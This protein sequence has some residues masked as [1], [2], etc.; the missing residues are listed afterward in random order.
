[1][2]GTWN[3]D[4]HP[5]GHVGNRGQFTTVT[6]ADADQSVTLTLDAPTEDDGAPWGRRFD[7]F[8]EKIAAYHAELEKGVEGLRDDAEFAR[9][10]D[11]MTL[12][13]RYSP[14]NQLMIALQRPDATLVAGY[15]RWQDVGRQV[16]KGEKGIA[17]WAPK[18]RWVAEADANGNEIRG[19]DG[20]PVKKKVVAGYTVA[21]VFDVEQTEGEEL[22]EGA[23][24][25]TTEPPAGYTE[26]LTRAIEAR[27]FAVSYEPIPGGTNGYTTADG[28]KKVVIDS[29]LSAGQRAK[30]LAHELGHIVLGHTDRAGEYH[31]GH[32]GQRGAMEVGAEAFSYVLCRANGMDAAETGGYSYGYVGGWSGGRGDTAVVKATADAVSKAVKDT[33]AAQPWTNLAADPVADAPRTERAPRRKTARRKTTARA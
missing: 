25:L 27:G 29:A 4:K 33:L 24:R 14:T 18:T 20:K 15:N 10:L 32:G 3:P 2:S 31:T 5:R 1:M 22:P 28:S 7:S 26:D 6:K 9:Y 11:T 12:F 30:T 19:A 16:K 23:R 21:T 17:I 8:E 13:H